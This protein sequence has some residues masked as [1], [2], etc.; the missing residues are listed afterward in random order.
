MK[1]L[2]QQVGMVLAVLI[3]TIVAMGCEGCGVD[4]KQKSQAYGQ[5]V[6]QQSDTQIILLSR[7]REGDQAACDGLA[8]SLQNQK[9]AAKTFEDTTGSTQ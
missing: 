1:R 5:A 8:S 9:A 7:C 4:I 3:V 6:A 2:R